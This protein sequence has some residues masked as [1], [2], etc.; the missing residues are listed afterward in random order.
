M[1]AP[2]P[3]AKRWLVTI[4][5]LAERRGHRADCAHVELSGVVYGVDADDARESFARTV[6]VTF[7]EPRSGVLFVLRVERSKHSTWR[8]RELAENERAPFAFGATS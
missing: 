4:G 7:A 6:P 5:N 1:N 3:R 2:A 8:V